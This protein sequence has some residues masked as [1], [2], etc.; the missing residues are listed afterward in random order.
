MGDAVPRPGSCR[1]LAPPS[2]TFPSAG[3]SKSPRTCNLA[4]TSPAIPLGARLPVSDYVDRRRPIN[5]PKARPPL[6]AVPMS[7]SG[8][9]SR[10]PVLAPPA[11]MPPNARK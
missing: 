10:L 5:A 7:S 9:S 6:D 4:T 8:L 2:A 3:I 1:R 11:V